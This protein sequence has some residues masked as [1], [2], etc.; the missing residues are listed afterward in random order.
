MDDFSLITE[1]QQPCHADVGL[2]VGG[3]LWLRPIIFL[4]LSP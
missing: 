2:R 3:H 1:A 4:F